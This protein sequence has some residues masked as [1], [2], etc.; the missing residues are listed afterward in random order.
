[1]IDHAEDGDCMKP[2]VI[3]LAFFSVPLICLAQHPKSVPEESRVPE[4]IA[5]CKPAV[6]ALGVVT[7]SRIADE[8]ATPVAEIALPNGQKNYLY[9]N[10]SG[11]FV[12]ADGLIVTAEHVV[13]NLP[14]PLPVILPDGK[15]MAARVVARSKERDFAVLKVDGAGLPFLQFGSF[16]DLKEGEELIFIGYPFMELREITHKG[17]VSWKGKLVWKGEEGDLPGA[18]FLQLNAIINNGNSGG[19]LIDIK[20]GRVVGIIKAKYGRLSPYLKDIKDGKVSSR[21]NLVGGGFDLLRFVKD[22]V[23]VVDRDIQMGVGFAVSGQYAEEQV[24]SILD[25]VRPKH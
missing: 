22:A 20:T 14:E 23:E 4:L 24:K 8:V 7:T 2:F 9:V 1:M 16:S 21:V 3:F 12:S 11:F 15:V 17:M 25:T 6:V 5:Q 13:S 10:G 18:N 19:P